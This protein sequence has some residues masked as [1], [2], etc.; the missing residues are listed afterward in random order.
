MAELGYFRKFRQLTL[1]G[2][3][4]DSMLLLGVHKHGN[5]NWDLIQVETNRR[6]WFTS[7]QKDKA[8]GLT[9]KICVNEAEKSDLPKVNASLSSH[10]LV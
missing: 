3:R 8:L 9:K 6:L 1:A 7:L 2:V 5:G 4:E 10:S